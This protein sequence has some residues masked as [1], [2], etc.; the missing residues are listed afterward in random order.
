[1]LRVLC[2]D[3]Y[4]CSCW[5][6]HYICSWPLTEGQSEVISIPPYA[7]D[8]TTC[9]SLP[10][11]WIS[12]GLLEFLSQ[13]PQSSWGNHQLLR[14]IWDLHW[15]NNSPRSQD[16]RD[17]ST[18]ISPNHPWF[19]TPLALPA[20]CLSASDWNSAY[21]TEME[22]DSCNGSC[23]EPSEVCPHPWIFRMWART[24]HWG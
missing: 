6:T 1:M 23:R 10:R 2:M 7:R 14:G 9:L 17:S 18:A 24:P 22:S 19:S 15:G 21:D 20:N 4:I 11:R 8:A 3:S 16:H 5:M 12:F 13:M